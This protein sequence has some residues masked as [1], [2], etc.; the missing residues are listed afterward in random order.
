[1]NADE[2]DGMIESGSDDLQMQD[3]MQ[4]VPLQSV[5]ILSGDRL[6]FEPGS[7]HIMLID[8]DKA[9]HLGD[10]LIVTLSLDSGEDLEVAVKV[11]E[12]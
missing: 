8:L 5:E 6:N 4:M 11:E 9:I 1:M 10:S 12:R 3:V 2:L 7:L